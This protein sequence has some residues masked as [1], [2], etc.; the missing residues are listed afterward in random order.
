MADPNTNCELGKKKNQ[1]R[2]LNLTFFWLGNNLAE[3][4]KSDSFIHI[5]LA[6]PLTLPPG[7]RRH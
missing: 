5:I 6:L 3:C 4:G 7:R 1:N 2:L